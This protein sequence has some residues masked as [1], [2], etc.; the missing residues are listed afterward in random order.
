MKKPYR[1]EFRAIPD[2]PLEEAYALAQGRVLGPQTVIYPNI[3]ADSPD[4]AAKKAVDIESNFLYRE[5]VWLFCE[6]TLIGEP[7][8]PPNVKLIFERKK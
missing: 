6:P 4:E 5:K 8:A 7:I 2:T 3:Y 1:V